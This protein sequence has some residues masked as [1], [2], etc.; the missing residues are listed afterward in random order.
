MSE[1]EP[2]TSTE[3]NPYSI[4]PPTGYSDI[5]RY[6]AERADSQMEEAWELQDKLNAPNGMSLHDMLAAME[7][8]DTRMH[9]IE[10]EYPLL[11][12]EEHKSPEEAARILLYSARNLLPSEAVRRAMSRGMLLDKRPESERRFRAESTGARHRKALEQALRLRSHSVPVRF[13][14]DG[15]DG[16]IPGGIK[17]GEVLCISSAAKAGLKR[18]CCFISSAITSAA[19]DALCS[20][21]WI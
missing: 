12:R 7:D 13:G 3:M 18:A 9:L 10:L 5:E 1:Y 2:V 20:F 8:E 17:V 15:L 6:L 14:I 16:L 4:Q 11:L 19:G 21:P